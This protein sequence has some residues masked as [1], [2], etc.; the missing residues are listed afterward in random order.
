MSLAK[1]SILFYIVITGII[2]CTSMA[3][4]YFQN[5]SEILGQG[6]ERGIAVIRTF[7]AAMISEHID[8]KST[9][10]NQILQLGIDELKKT[11]PELEDFTVYSIADKKAVASLIKEDVNEA[12]DPEDIEAAKEDQT[13]AIIT[14]EGGNTI[15]DVTAPLHINNKIDYVCSVSFSMNDE[16][17]STHAFLIRTIVVSLIALV[18]GIF[19]IWFLNIRKMSNQLKE[20]ME[21]SDQV[22]IGNLGV[23]STII[24]K[25]EIGQLSKNINNMSLSLAK[26]ISNV[27]HTSKQVSSYSQNLADVSNE[28]TVSIDE[29][30][31]TVDELAKG[32]S[33]QTME[34]K[35]GA[36]KLSMLANQI[37]NIL[38]SSNQIKHYTNKTSALNQ[39]G[40]DV[41]KQLAEKFKE[42][43]D[44]SDKMAQNANTLLGKSSSVS[45]V[46]D[47]IQAIAEQTNLLALNAA[48][49][50][51]RAGEQGKGFAVVAEEIRKLAEQTSS[52]TNIISD[53]VEEI[54]TEIKTTK[55]NI[56]IGASSL[57]H[58]NRKLID[59]TKAF[60]AISEAVNNSKEHLDTLT[61]NIQKISTD[62]DEVVNLI[63]EISAISENTAAAT[64]EVS[65]TVEEQ[66][67]TIVDIAIT[68]EK[69]REVAS[70]LD[71]AVGEFKF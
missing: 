39:E 14:S 3:I 67:A 32:A 26:I 47:A 40:R 24:S 36:E 58:V 60:E 66:A 7:E 69:L 38:D 29:I 27:I 44:V 20:L 41:L 50:A 49:E 59:T 55:N 34:A 53:I 31:K 56:D 62:K 6:E 9:V 5:K 19:L 21:V 13:V 11:L 28:T 57:E 64:E 8:V 30:A 71:K 51:A 46:V 68:A 48:I 15:V 18:V 4:M 22:A 35:V 2:F 1:K 25:D 33:D 37:N 45:Q 10:F 70:E 17:S 52:S 23:K 65:A 16:M 12:A 63:R 43:N 42:N 61:L 54:Q